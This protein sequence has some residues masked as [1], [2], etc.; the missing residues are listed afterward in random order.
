MTVDQNQILF[1]SYQLSTK[2]NFPAD[3]CVVPFES[4]ANIFYSPDW[5]ECV[6]AN[7]KFPSCGFYIDY[8][9]PYVWAKENKSGFGWDKSELSECDGDFWPNIANPVR[10]E[11]MVVVA[12]RKVDMREIE[13]AF[14]FK[15]KIAEY[16]LKCQI[17]DD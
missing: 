8:C 3:E 15:K 11:N 4:E 16:G 17:W 10:N 2:E 7:L 6:I 9:K 13:T 5:Y 14:E 12:F 1:Q